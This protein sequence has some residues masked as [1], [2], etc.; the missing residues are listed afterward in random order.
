MSGDVK[1]YEGIRKVEISLL[2]VDSGR[3]EQ[4]TDLVAVE[5]PIHILLNEEHYAT[6]LCLSLIHISEPTRP[7]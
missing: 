2:R 6:I 3:V 4:R 7:Y 1:G 5:Q